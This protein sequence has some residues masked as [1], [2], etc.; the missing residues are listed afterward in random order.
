MDIRDEQKYVTYKSL[1]IS[2]G[3][4]CMVILIIFGLYVNHMDKK[5]NKELYDRDYNFLSTNISSIQD[6]VKSNADI[7]NKFGRNQELVLRALR[8]EPVR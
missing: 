8:I 2:L 6:I 7:L 4:V 1:F 3:S 5:V